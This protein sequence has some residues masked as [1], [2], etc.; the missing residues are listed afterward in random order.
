MQYELLLR[1]LLAGICGVIIGYERKNRMKEAGVR[2]HFVVAVG[3]ALMMIISK[4]GFQDQVGWENLSVDP[5][6]IAAGVVSGVSFLGAGMIFMQKQTIKG[7][8]TAAGIWATSGIGM[9]VGAG[10][11]WIGLGVTLI[12]FVGQVLM[13]SRFGGKSLATPRSEKIHVLLQNEAGAAER[14]LNKLKEQHIQ[15]TTFSM[16]KLETGLSLEAVV[17]WKVEM[18]PDQLIALLSELSDVRKAEL[19]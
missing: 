19:E 10:L 4:Y 8:T 18:P 7:L 3:A 5:S 15:V 13:H 16:E 6:R 12:I 9:A 14:L 11:Y 1:V 17:K 2:T